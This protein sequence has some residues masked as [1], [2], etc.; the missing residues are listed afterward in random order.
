MPPPV[1]LELRRVTT[2]F[3]LEFQSTFKRGWQ[4]TFCQRFLLSTRTPATFTWFRGAGDHLK[5]YRNEEIPR[6]KTNDYS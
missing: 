4:T 3:D 5:N 6:L 2:K 1:Y